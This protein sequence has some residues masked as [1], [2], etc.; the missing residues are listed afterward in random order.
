MVMAKATKANNSQQGGESC[1]GPAGYID[2]R[3]REAAAGLNSK[4]VLQRAEQEL[5]WKGQNN[6]SCLT[7]EAAA[8][9][10]QPQ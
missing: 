3:R 2:Q 8:I 10:L 6:Q 7:K 9:G 4:G 1:Q 5:N